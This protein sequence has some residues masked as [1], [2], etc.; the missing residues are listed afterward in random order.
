MSPTTHFLVEVAKTPGPILAGVGALIA[1]PAW[2]TSRSTQ[3]HQNSKTTIDALQDAAVG[4]FEDAKYRKFLEDVR[5]EKL[6]SMAFGVPVRSGDLGRLMDYYDKGFASTREIGLAWDHRSDAGTPLSFHL[7]RW[8]RFFFWAAMIYAT[9]CALI[10]VG[11]LAL[12]FALPAAKAWGFAPV[13]AVYLLLTFLTASFF[14]GHLIAREL[15]ERE[16]K[17]G[18]A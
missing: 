14:R 1:L 2:W 15:H 12:L 4:S 18:I 6:A 10:G 17:R 8:T 9:V 5:K 13:P 11:S 3:L 7:G 16:K